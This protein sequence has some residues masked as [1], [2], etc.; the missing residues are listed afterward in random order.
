MKR[1]L[2]IPLV[3]CLA[4]IGPGCGNVFIGGAIHPAV[5]TITGTVS[6]IEVNSV[7]SNGSAIQVTFVTFLANGTM[8]SIG[9]CGDQSNQFPLNQTVTM[10]FTPGQPCATLVV[11]VSVTRGSADPSSGDVRSRHQGT[12]IG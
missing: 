11:V 5:S 3:L 2:T 4:A 10:N 12:F 6:F 9:F 7:I 1:L 8:S